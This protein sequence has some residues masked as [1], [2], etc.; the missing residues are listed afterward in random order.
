MLFLI[1]YGARALGLVAQSRLRG[2]LEVIL[3]IGAHRTGTSSLQTALN[4]NK[5]NLTKNRVAY[6]GPGDTR[7]GLLSGLLGRSGTDH[8]KNLIARNQGAV[9]IEMDRLQDQ[10]IA[11]LLVSEENILGAML[12]NLK[13]GLLYPGLTARLEA[14]SLL[15]GRKLVRVAVAIRPYGPYW[16]SVLA[17]GIRTGRAPL[18]E[19]GLDRLVTQPRH[20]RQVIT[21]VASAFP[22]AEIVVWDFDRLIGHPEQQYRL[23]TNG[24]GRIN[25]MRRRCN[26]TPDRASLR[27]LLTDRGQHDAA[28]AIADGNGRYMPFGAHHLTAFDGQYRDDI[29]WLRVRSADR[30]RFERAAPQVAAKTQIKWGLG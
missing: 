11:T 28:T 10:G 25:P 14:F 12:D 29:S 30:V 22:N 8:A 13:S 26:A 24:R 9:A 21:D 15:F 19:A 7:G 18:D 16:A 3:H 23:L 6:W 27:G 4:R 2:Y 5:N 20:W 1:A 17:Y